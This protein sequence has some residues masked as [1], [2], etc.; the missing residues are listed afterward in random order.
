MT[1]PLH[2]AFVWHMHQPYYK[3]DLTGTYLLPWVRLRCAK[4]YHKMPALLDAYP[5]IH[6]TF[7]LVP[8]LLAQI[9]DYAS[10]R[11]ED[12]F[13]NLARKPAADLTFEERGF[14]LRWM[15]ESP[16]FLRVQQSPRYLELASRPEDPSAFSV[17]DMA[18]LQVWSN[19]AWFD[20][21]MVEQDPRLAALKVK[22]SGFDAEDKRV[23]FDLQLAMAGR[24]IP[25]YRQLAARGQAELTFS[26]QYHPILPLLQ[27]VDSAREA[28]PGIDLGDL[29]FAHPEDARSQLRAGRELF[30][31]R[32]GFEPAGMWPP[33]LAVSEGV[34]QLACE[35]GVE[36]MVTDEE[37]LARSLGRRLDRDG[38][39]RL[40]AP[41]LL[42]QPWYWE[43]DG[44]RVS[45]LFRDTTLSNLI[46][47]DYCRRPAV[48]AA[49]DFMA[50]L[51]SIR[52]LQGERDFCVVVALD[53]ENAWEFFPRDGHDFLNALYDELSGA[54]DVVASTVGE[55]LREHPSA[56]A[57]PHLPAGSWIGANLDTWI[58]DPEHNS[59]WSALAETRGWLEAQGEALAPE[60]RAAAWREIMITEG[61][62][63]FWWFGRKHDSG[64]DAI[65][66]NQFR[67]HLRNVYKLA[68]SRPPSRLFQP[69]IARASG[70]A[71]RPPGQAISPTGPDDVAWAEA[72]RYEVGS[73]F[74]ALYRPVG[75]IE[76]LLYGADHENLHLRLDATAAPEEFGSHGTEF[77]IYLSGAPLPASEESE[78]L[79]LDGAG[80][81]DLGFE[82]GFAVRLSPGDPEA[83]A[84]LYH[85]IAPG[86]GGRLIAAVPRPSRLTVRIP[87]RLIEKVD[88]EPMELALTVARGGRPLEQVPPVGSIG[89][90]VPEQVGPAEGGTRLR[91]LIASAELAP[92]AKSGGLADVPAALAKELHRLGH[93]VRLV[94][95]RY[96]QMNDFE[97]LRARPAV[98]HLEVPLGAGSTT[99]SILE[100][101]MGEVPVYLVDCPPLYA[102]DALYGYG[103]DDARFIYLSRALIEML[104]PLGWTPDVVHLNDWHTALVPNLL[105]RVYGD[106]PRLS[107]IATV[108][109]IHNIGFQGS[110]GSGSLLLAGLDRWGLMRVGIPH[111]DD[112]FNILGRGIHF[113]DVFSTVSERYAQ[114]MQSDGFGEGLEELIRA[115]AHKL[116]GIVNGIDVEVFDPASD[117]SL[118]MRYSVED[119]S[120]K[121]AAKQALLQ[122]A[123]LAQPSGPV[124]GMVS[125]LYDQKGIEILLRAIP[126]MAGAGLQLV[127]LG[128]GDRSYEDALRIEAAR[129]PGRVSI[130]I[131]FDSR[132]AR[133]IYAGSDIFLM[134]SRFEPCGLG[135]LISMRY[136]TVPV[137]RATGGLADTVSDY[138]P[139]ADTGLGFVFSEYDPWQ[140]FG[141][142]VRA[143]ESFRHRE[144]WV[145]LMRRDMAQDVSWSRSAR[146][147]VQLYR[148]AI[149]AHRDRRGAAGATR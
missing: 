32:L 66:D 53:G 60:P 24:V 112:V 62:D 30:R 126:A 133:L 8:S 125:R 135:Q 137:V 54:D 18:D 91:V 122:E 115:H 134:P 146:S 87:L 90:R 119:L 72:G 93:D 20:P 59:A 96:R 70:D 34:A 51:R 38:E 31:S 95:P 103:D 55:Y 52:V 42:Y 11:F 37:V 118:P 113:S 9:D 148:A 85:V 80:L 69:I 48:A 14:V 97:S 86:G 13:L 35:E 106:D 15:R 143:A 144:A 68:G 16:D 64:M 57:L 88:G 130:R 116:Y 141:A 41:E 129:N 149:G 2:V 19:L 58:G 4:D 73:G 138:D 100:G 40:T 131:G 82:P 29:Q 128:A 123:Q 67:L 36:W 76:R 89:M 132:L 136:G 49:R 77:W 83:P 65:W 12:L 78:P 120:G 107:G 28:L 81:A 25:K 1:R 114:E 98:A 46:S 109:T 142:V 44:R 147:Y 7:N 56:Q 26:P 3:D 5:R 47:F 10:G 84:A 111:L 43:R 79:P 74:G 124:I 108:L 145:R 39:G 75:M 94:M 61:S 102:R 71:P 6:Q 63:W 45:V 33:E 101:R 17:R 121:V 140:L 21:A 105:E 139:A 104:E 127:L 99:C 27:G 117:P 92:Y 50:R 110:Y 23:L 22:D